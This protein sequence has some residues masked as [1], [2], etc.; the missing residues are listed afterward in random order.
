[1]IK[2]LLVDDEIL[3]INYLKALI[4]WNKAGFEIVGYASDGAHALDL[5]DQLRPHLIISDI[6]MPRRDG[7]YLCK[8]LKNRKLNIPVILLTA[9]QDFEYAQQ[10]IEAGVHN[11]I[12]K[13]QLTAEMLHSKLKS[14][15]DEIKVQQQNRRILQEKI[16]ND[17]LF[18]KSDILHA[19]IPVNTDGR[20]AVILVRKDLPFAD[21]Y[22]QNGKS[23][24]LGSTMKESLTSKCDVLMKYDDYYINE[25]ETT[26][27]INFSFQTIADIPLDDNHRVIVLSQKREYSQSKLLRDITFVINEIR[28]Q[29][30][31]EASHSVSVLY[32]VGVKWGLLPETFNRLARSMR[33]SVFFG[34]DYAGALPN[35]FNLISESERVLD[36]QISEIIERVA[37]CIAELVGSSALSKHNFSINETADPT[38]QYN[39]IY[40][41]I[42]LSVYDLVPET[43]G[44]IESSIQD[45][46]KIIAKPVWNLSALRYLCENLNGLV[47]DI[48]KEHD[49]SNSVLLQ[50]LPTLKQAAM[51]IDQ[52]KQQYKELIIYSSVV[53]ACS[54]N[55]DVVYSAIVQR[56]INFIDSRY[57]DT[58]TLDDIGQALGVHGNYLG[59]LF[60][61]ETGTTF[62]KYLTNRRIDVAKRLLESG[63]HNITE[64]ADMVGYKTTQ[65]FGKIFHDNVGI[66]P[67]QYKNR[68]K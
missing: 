21:S 6:K 24:Q 36:S 46:F 5:I 45:A 1:M 43:V 4:D 39:S 35:V 15:C 44:E 37:K 26:A 49:L 38:G 57:S 27:A 51:N 10:A 52:L 33:Y 67:N 11:Y 65:Y 3:V 53:A 28:Y 18:G 58:I 23:G 9:Y 14:V 54:D 29:Y 17:L 42:M 16:V 8:E 50:D 13:H 62:L 55:K 66:T 48:I 32:G 19:N 63:E 34:P 40:S 7:L 47:K 2:V 20:F 64:V 41:D 61:K 25:P 22:F 59:N 30:I 60:K 31:N 68:R 56:A 12:L